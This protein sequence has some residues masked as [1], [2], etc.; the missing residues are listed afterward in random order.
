M[1]DQDDKLS[2]ANVKGGAAIEMFDLALNRVFT[3]I[4]DINTTMDK[5]EITLKMVIQPADE[6]RT[7]AR[8]TWSV[9]TKLANQGAE[10]ATIDI[11]LDSKGRPYGREREKQ[12]GLNLQ[13]N[14]VKDFEQF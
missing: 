5:R 9:G 12:L 3:N 7:L 1:T 14:N 13:V 4:R 2:L 10:K 8:I 6:G 11:K